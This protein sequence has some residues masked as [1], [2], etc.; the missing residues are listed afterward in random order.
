MSYP[1]IFRERTIEYRQAGHTL[2]E[3]SKT[4]Q[5]SIETIR[6][7]EKQLKE[8]GHLEKKPLNWQHK[9]IDPEKLKAYVREHPDAY[10][11]EMAEEFGCSAT[12]IQKA[13]KRLGITRKKDNALSGT[14][15]GDRSGIFGANCRHSSGEDRVHR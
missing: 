2:E 12:A 10:Q 4:F 7:W 3:T 11:K 15:S 13:L 9:K 14:K 8:R 6:Q 5:V 1:R